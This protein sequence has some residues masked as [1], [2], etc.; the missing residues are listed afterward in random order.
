M[1]VSILI[2]WRA[3]VAFVLIINDK[4]S[5]FCL[6]SALFH[7]PVTYFLSLT[8]THFV[9]L[10]LHH[11]HFLFQGSVALSIVFNFFPLHTSFEHWVNTITLLI[12]K[13]YLLGG[14]ATGNE[15]IKVWCVNVNVYVQKVLLD[16]YDKYLAPFSS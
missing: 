14:M 13:Y 16:F 1:H 10:F 2:K 7:Y 9:S 11:F 15:G 5:H 8:H 4:K 3:P 6:P 12:I